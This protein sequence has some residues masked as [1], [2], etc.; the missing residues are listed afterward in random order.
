MALVERNLAKSVVIMAGVYAESF[1]CKIQ[2]S[3]RGEAWFDGETISIP[4]PIPEMLDVTWGFCAHEAGHKRYSDLSVFESV[5][6]DPIAEH[7]LQV[8]EDTRIETAMLTPFPGVRKYFAVTAAKVIPY[9]PKEDATPANLLSSYIFYYVRGKLTGYPIWDDNTK[10]LE[11]Q[12]TK[13]LNFFVMSSLM[14]LLDD[15]LL[16][17][18]S[19]DSLALAYRVKA[20]LKDLVDQPEKEE[21][22]DNNQSSENSDSSDEG[23]GE[24]EQ[25]SNASDSSDDGDDSQGSASDSSD[26]GEDDGQ[27]SASDSSD[28]GD[29]GQDTDNAPSA[30]NSGKGAGGLNDEGREFIQQFLEATT[31]DLGESDLGEILKEVLSQDENQEPLTALEAENVGTGSELQIDVSPMEISNFEHH[32][33]STTNTL[34]HSLIR[35]IEDQTRSQRQTVRRGRRIAKSKV[36]RLAT[37]NTRIFKRKFTEREEVNCDVAVLADS[38]GSMGADMEAVKVATFALLQCLDQIEGA[39]TCC[40]AFGIGESNLVEVQRPG[41]HFGNKVKGRIASLTA[42]NSTPA[43]EAYWAA[44]HALFRM[45]SNKKVAIMITDGSPNNTSTTKAIVDTLKE[46]D[47]KV[48]CVGVGVTSY[49]IPQLDYVYGKGVWLNVK[50]FTDLPSELLRVAKEVI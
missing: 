16:T 17:Q 38:S 41:E 45:E 4:K 2:L 43:T 6:N 35:L 47:V 28:D 11:L 22:E 5:S 29:D 14:E 20:F 7:L 3:E 25:G 40:Y 37:G 12:L 36:H 48:M 44:A 10:A 19:A 21:P 18:S 24:E 50:K 13:S 31:E 39:Q 23:E 1:G 42:W 46:N 15:T 34:R 8:I 26:D 49:D 30:N 9:Q 32:S 33:I 27:G